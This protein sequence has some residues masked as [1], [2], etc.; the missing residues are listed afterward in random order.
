[1][2]ENEIK[3]IEFIESI[4]S[5]FPYNNEV[6]STKLIEEGADISPN[7]SFMV[8]YEICMAS[9]KISKENFLRLLT[10]WRDSIS[11]PLKNI[12]FGLG[13]IFISGTKMSDE[14]LMK[15]MKKIGEYPRQYNALNLVFSLLSTQDEKVEKKYNQI[16]SE[17]RSLP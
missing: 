7:A 8:L 15:V 3:E 17:W 14:D 2:S 13:Q 1:M 6:E 16:V 9:D 5:C 4:D 12:M 10:T 11:H